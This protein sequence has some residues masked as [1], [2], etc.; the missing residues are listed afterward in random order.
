MPRVR[1]RKGTAVRADPVRGAEA[2]RFDCSTSKAQENYSAK[3]KS[4]S[5]DCAALRC[6][7]RHR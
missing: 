1:Q 7:A 2:P 3:R 6:A 4:G 5:L